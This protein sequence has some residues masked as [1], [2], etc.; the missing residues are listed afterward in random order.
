MTR[1]T[2]IVK[3]YFAGQKTRARASGS[4]D[5]T[6]GLAARPRALIAGEIALPIAPPLTQLF[7]FSPSHQHTRM[8]A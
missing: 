4:V 3:D 6:V 8:F 5:R 1:E 2:Q 7:H